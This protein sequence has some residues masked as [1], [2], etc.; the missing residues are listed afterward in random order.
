MLSAANYHKKPVIKFRLVGKETKMLDRDMLNISERYGD[1][2]FVMFSKKTSKEEI[3]SKMQLM[4]SLMEQKL[5]VE[6]VGMSIL[7]SNLEELG[8]EKSFDSERMFHLLLEG[9][10]DTITN[11]LAGKQDALKSW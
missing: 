4:K 11:M 10:L 9:E 8:F 2:A 1:R 6:E 7:N 3:G 5:S